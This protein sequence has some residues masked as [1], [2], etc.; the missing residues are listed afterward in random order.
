L[1][2]EDHHALLTEGYGSDTA[3]ALTA[4]T[5][6]EKLSVTYIPSTGTD[7][8]ELTVAM[9]RF[10]KPVT[11]RWYNPTNGRLVEVEGS[12]YAN[13]ATHHFHTPGDN[14]TGTNDWV[15]ILGAR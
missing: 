15:L 10:E 9:D 2:P 11:A 14:G 1:A 7:G 5:A 4:L 13:R 8:R 6:D 3:T 12:P